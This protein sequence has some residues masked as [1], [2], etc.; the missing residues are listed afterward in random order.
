MAAPRGTAP[1]DNFMNISTLSIL[2][3]V[4]FAIPQIYALAKP[5]EFKELA[6]KFPRSNTAGYFLVG[7]ATAWFVYYVGLESVADFAPIKKYL[8]WGFVL[9]GV[10][11]CLFV[12]DFLAVRGLAVVLLLLAKLTVD[13]AR[14]VDSPWRLVLVA[15]AYLWIL[16]GIW[17]TISPWRLRDLILWSTANEA[18]LKI[19]SGLRLAFAVVVICLGIFVF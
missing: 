9:L 5:D 14:W 3:G 7:L 15:W 1:L 6:R 10:G 8:M 4:G 19:G 16:A 13:T 12:K 17:F 11:T 2:L 18:R